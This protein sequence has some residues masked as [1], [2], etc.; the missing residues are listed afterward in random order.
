ML[1]I[2]PINVTDLSLQAGSY[3]PTLQEI[4]KDYCTDINVFMLS[5]LVLFFVR[6]A[7]L[8]I[9][10]Y[11]YET[12][13]NTI[14]NVAVFA[15]FGYSLYFFWEGGLFKWYHYIGI[16]FYVIMLAIDLVRGFAKKT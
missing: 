1:N 4:I 11:K 14:L 8:F 5:V 9:T 16:L 2:T 10:E 13:V 15:G 3:V 7:F 12:A 6:E